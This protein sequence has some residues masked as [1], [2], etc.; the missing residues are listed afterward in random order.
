MRYMPPCGR[1]GDHRA[2]RLAVPV[3]HLQVPTFALGGWLQIKMACM[4]F[5]PQSLYKSQHRVTTHLHV[6]RGALLHKAPHQVHARLVAEAHLPQQH[7]V[8]FTILGGGGHTVHVPYGGR[9]A[10][11]VGR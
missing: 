4:S 10:G 11:H 8:A 9:A 6:R 2:L 5:S 7:A 3:L 1:R